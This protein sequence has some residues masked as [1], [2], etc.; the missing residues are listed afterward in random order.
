MLDKYLQYLEKL[1]KKCKSHKISNIHQRDTLKI[2]HV[3]LNTLKCKI[4]AIE[5]FETSNH[6]LSGTITNMHKDRQKLD[7]IRQSQTKIP[8]KMPILALFSIKYQYTTPPH[9]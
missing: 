7:K 2:N 8:T 6:R 1:T 5:K 9:T 3:I 4:L